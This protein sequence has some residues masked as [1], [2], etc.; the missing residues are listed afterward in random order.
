[1]IKNNLFYS[2]SSIMKQ[3]GIAIEEVFS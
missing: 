1:M 3:M 2:F